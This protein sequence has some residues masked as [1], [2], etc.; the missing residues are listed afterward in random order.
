MVNILV[1]GDPAM[2]AASHRPIEQGWMPSPVGHRH[3]L[4][5]SLLSVG[6]CLGLLL[7]V[8]LVSAW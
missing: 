6:A 5:G 7:V 1:V 8:T 4:G 3:Q 2:I